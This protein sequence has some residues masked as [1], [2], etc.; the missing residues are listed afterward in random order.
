MNNTF[1]DELYQLKG[2]LS[3]KHHIP[4]RIRLKFDL[5]I[6]NKIGHFLH[7]KKQINESPI[8]KH[9]QVNLLTGSILL[10]YSQTQIPPEIIDQMFAGDEINSRLA[11]QKITTIISDIHHEQAFNPLLQKHIQKRL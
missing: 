9:Y 3:V 10:E 4:G 2:Y 8:V 5:A 7:L 11:Y 1:L 6:V